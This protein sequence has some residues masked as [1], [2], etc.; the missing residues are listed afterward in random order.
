MQW[1]S[2]AKQKKKKKLCTEKKKNEYGM[3]SKTINGIR[4]F[5]MA[6]GWRWR[7]KRGKIYVEKKREGRAGLD[8]AEEKT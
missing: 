4:S 6:N 7:E 8:W 2:T 3:V 5:E 1:F